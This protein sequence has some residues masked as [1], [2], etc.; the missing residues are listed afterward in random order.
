M[1]S[2]LALLALIAHDSAHSFTARSLQSGTTNRASDYSQP[3]MATVDE[4]TPSGNGGNGE[5]NNS[6]KKQTAEKPH[7]V[8]YVEACCAVLLVLITGT[9]TYYAAGQLHK[10][11]R[12][13]DAAE[14]AAIA[15]KSAADTATQSMRLEQRAWVGPAEVA[16]AAYDENGHKVYIK[17]GEKPR[18]SF[19][20]SNSGK[21]PALNLTFKITNHF[22]R[23]TETFVP[24]YE[25]PKTNTTVGTLFPG[26]RMKLDTL[27]TP[28]VAERAQVSAL[29]KGEYIDYIY[30]EVSYEDVFGQPHKTSFCTYVDKTLTQLFSC[31]TYNHAD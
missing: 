29:S 19:M 2:K 13:T 6:Y 9:Y 30:G 20:L 18:F 10:M 4:R 27:E 17:V 22:Y 25:E 5:S 7:W 31:A 24:Y 21:T 23:S 1:G 28:G 15:A 8:A 12:S 3:P 26:V 11:K 16:P 14:R